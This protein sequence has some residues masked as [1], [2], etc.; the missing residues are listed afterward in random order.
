VSKKGNNK[1]GPATSRIFQGDQHISYPMSVAH[2]HEL[3]MSC[4]ILK[5]KEVQ[6]YDIFNL[7]KF[8]THLKAILLLRP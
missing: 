4:C 1:W 6:V 8:F 7:G 3:L 2:A 5:K